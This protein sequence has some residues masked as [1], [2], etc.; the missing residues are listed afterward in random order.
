MYYEQYHVLTRSVYYIWWVLVGFDGFW[1]VLMVFDGFWFFRVVFSIYRRLCSKIEV[2]MMYVRQVMHAAWKC[3]TLTMKMRDFHVR[4]YLGGKSGRSL[5]VLKRRPI[6]F[7]YFTKSSSSSSYLVM[8]F[9]IARQHSI[10]PIQPTF[11]EPAE[12]EYQTRSIQQTKVLEESLG[13][14]MKERRVRGSE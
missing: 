5:E 13:S 7:Q 10:R 14:T 11:A 1:R 4:L 2:Y 9:V 12:S 8:I 6:V 3:V